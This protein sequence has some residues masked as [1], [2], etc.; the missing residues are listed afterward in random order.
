MKKILLLMTIAIA[1]LS[2]E[3]PMGP[4]GPKGDVAD[5]FVNFYV[6]GERSNQYEYGYWES[7]GDGKFQCVFDIPELDDFVYNEGIVNVFF[8][9]D[10]DTNNEIQVGFPH[11]FFYEDYGKTYTATYTFD[12]Q[13]IKGK[14]GSIAFNVAYSD[15][16]DAPPPA[17]TFRVAMIW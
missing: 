7:L 1:A 2:C 6:V 17:C 9:Q 8:M 5:W 4:Q 15:F 13:K 14:M 12:M 11:I 16:I 10:M 3:G